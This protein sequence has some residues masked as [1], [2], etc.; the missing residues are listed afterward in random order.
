MASFQSPLLVPPLNPGASGINPQISFLA[1]L[2]TPWSF[3]KW[4]Y[5]RTS[6][7]IC[8]LIT[9]NLVSPALIPMNFWFGL[10]AAYSVSLV[11]GW[12][13]IS[14]LTRFKTRPRQSFSLCRLL[15]S[16]NG[17]TLL[18]LPRPE[19][20]NLPSPLPLTSQLPSINNTAVLPLATFRRPLLIVSMTTDPGH[21]A[22]IAVW[23][24]AINGPACVHPCT[25]TINSPQSSQSE[26]LK[27]YI[28]SCQSPA[29]TPP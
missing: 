18:Q 7:G 10:P 8:I 2:Y 11:R 9:F 3:L 12:R 27:N 4:P 16:V 1:I 22:R 24:T 29:R 26:L 19:H 6:H 28:G 20:M 5:P 17:N 25:F 15:N 21:A 14:N 23:V 13:V